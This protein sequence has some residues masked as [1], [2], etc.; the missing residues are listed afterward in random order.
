M[1]KRLVIIA[2]LF[3]TMLSPVAISNTSY[4]VNVLPICSG[5]TEGGSAGAP[6]NASTTEVCQ[7][8]SSG[9]SSVLVTTLKTVFNIFSF[10][11]GIAAVIMLVIGGIKLVLSQ[12]DSSNIA[13]GR[14][15]IIYALAGLAVAA[16]AQV[17]VVFVLDKLK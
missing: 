13:S 8:A 7:S 3:V 9:G 11:I 4:A 6:T 12:G 5:S 1:K 16:L 10:V 14:S 17:I 15:T 2:G